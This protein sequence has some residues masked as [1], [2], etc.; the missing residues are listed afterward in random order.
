MSI[1]PVL[2][3]DFD[4]VLHPNLAAEG[5]MFSRAPLLAQALEGLHVD[6]VVS[7]SWRFQWELAQL[8][9]L[10]PAALQGEGQGRDRACLCR[11]PCQVA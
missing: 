6:I 1:A 11:P 2:F 10:L 3:L 9:A 7:S 4:G 8:R 5:Q